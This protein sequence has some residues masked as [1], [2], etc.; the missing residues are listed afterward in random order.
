MALVDRAIYGINSLE[1][2]HMVAIPPG[3]DQIILRWN[4]SV[5]GL[6]ILQT[7]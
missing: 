7:S 3:E 1:D 2:L 5:L 4:G 6:P